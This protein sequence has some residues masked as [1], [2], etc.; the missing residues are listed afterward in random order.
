MAAFRVL[1]ID[2]NPYALQTI[3]GALNGTG[4]Q[5]ETALSGAEGL[6]KAASSPPDAVLLD[7]LMPGI[8]GLEVLRRIREDPS[9]AEVPVIVVTSL[10]ERPARIEALKAGADDFIGKP[11]NV[12]ELRAR[13]GTLAKLNRFRRLAAERARLSWLAEGSRD[14]ILLLRHDGKTSWTNE[15]ARRLLCLPAPPKDTGQPFVER[16]LALY[17]PVPPRALDE[18]AGGAAGKPGCFLVRP[19]CG[20]TPPLWLHVEILDAG[21]AALSVRLRD[22]TAT[23]DSFRDAWSVGGTLQHKLRTPLSG[24]LGTLEEL[25]ARGAGQSP[26]ELR[27]RLDLARQAADR[28]RGHLLDLADF[29]LRLTTPDHGEGASAEGIRQ[30]AERAAALAGAPQGVSR[31]RVEDGTGSLPISLPRLESILF[32]LFRN[33]VRA[34]PEGSPSLE[35]DLR[36]ARGGLALTV[37][38]DGVRLPPEALSGLWR[39]LYQLDGGVTGEATGTGLGLT[40]VALVAAEAGGSLHLCNRDPGPGV[41]VELRFREAHAR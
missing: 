31:V 9:L 28:L 21:Q 1:V 37:S 27:A 18:L 14:G 35:L 11:V 7:L 22:V 32:E 15:A 4:Y 5:V 24:I 2:D 16:A 41:E 23:V 29:G 19:A 34:H 36:A 39:P 26:E 40:Y 30:A 13:L 12:P 38:D 17:E 33:S 25:C 8:D 6:E 10:D 20:S 3:E